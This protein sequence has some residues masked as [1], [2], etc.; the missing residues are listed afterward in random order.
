MTCFDKYSLAPYAV[1][2][3]RGRAF[4]EPPCKFRTD[5]QRDHD[6]IVHSEAFR[7]LEYK[8][9]VF[10]NHEGD[11]YRT[12]LT[13]TLEVAQMARG[14]ART[15]KLNE[16]LAETI[17]L[18]H[19]LGHTPFGHS[20]EAVLDGLMKKHGGFEHNLQSHRVVTILERRYPDFQGLNLTKEVL[21]GILKH[22]GPSS[23]E[24]EIVN[25]ADEIAYMNHDLDDGLESGMI[26][27]EQLKDVKLWKEIY[28]PIVKKYPKLDAQMLRYQVIRTLIHILIGDVKDETLR[29]IKRHKIGSL[30]DALALGKSI[31]NFSKEVTPKVKELKAFLFKNLYRHERVEKMAAQAREVLEKLFSIYN[32]NT[33]ILPKSV[34]ARIGRRDKKERVICDY[35]AGMTDRFALDEYKKLTP[36]NS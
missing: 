15:L 33:K 23:L 24:A 5:F 34:Q 13:H 30:K 14:I 2:E 3:S 12:R 26:T 6:R 7:R 22:H 25:I 36:N 1:R 20:G 16:D 27:I 11:Y 35:I 32:A 9:Q 4:K 8:T 21:D 19:D 17:A 10:V 28:Q 18:A 31:V 29:Q